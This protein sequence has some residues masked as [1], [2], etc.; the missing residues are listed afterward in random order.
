MK[1]PLDQTPYPKDPRSSPISS[2]TADGGYAFVRDSQ[3]VIHIVPDGPHVHPRILGGGLPAN[4]A[5][6]LTI[7]G[8]KVI[9]VTNLS[10][11]FQ[12]DDPQGLRDVAEE[13]RHQ[14][15]AVEPGAVRFFP[16][17]GSTPLVLE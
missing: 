15:I 16:S 7:Q 3:G 9:D 6:D 14:G 10:G 13:L 4:Y 8:G 17:D 1:A 11:S 12:F 5:G 2:C